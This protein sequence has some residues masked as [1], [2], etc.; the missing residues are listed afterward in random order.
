MAELAAIGLASNLLQFVDIGIKLFSRARES[1]N[2]ASG[3][4]EADEALLADTERL[5]QLVVTIR[6]TSS[7]YSAAENKIQELAQEFDGTATKLVKELEGFRVVVER[8]EQRD[9]FRRRYHGFGK[10]LRSAMKEGRSKK[11]LEKLVGDLEKQ[12]GLIQVYMCAS[13]VEKQ[14]EVLATVENLRRQNDWLEAKTTEKLEYITGDV[15]RVVEMMKIG[16]IDNLATQFDAFGTSVLAFRNETSRVNKQQRI[17]ESLQF[18]KIRMRQEAIKENYGA[19]FRWI[20][21][22][23][24]TSFSRWLTSEN[25]IFWIRGKAGCGKS[26]LMKFLVSEPTMRS[27]LEVWGGQNKLIVASHYFWNVGNSMQKS[28]QGLLQTLLHEVLKELPDVIEEVCSS[29]WAASQH[30]RVA[31]WDEDELMAALKALAK[32]SPKLSVRFCFFID[33]LDEYTAGEDRYYGLCEDLIETLIEL[34]LVPEIKICASSRPWSSFVE[35]FGAGEWQ[36]KMEDLTKDDINKIAVG[37]LNKSKHYE[38]LAREDSRCAQ[39]PGIIANRAQGVILWVRLVVESLKRGLAK[40]DTYEELQARLDELPDDLEKYFQHMLETIEPLYW[41]STTRVFKIMVDSGQTLPLLAFEFLDRE[42]RDAD[43]SLALDSKPFSADGQDLEYTYS[44]LTTRLNERAKDLLETTPCKDG[45]NFLRYQFGFLHRTVR[46]WFREN[47]PLDKEIAK[48]KTKEFSPLLS[49]CRIMLALSKTIPYPDDVPDSNQV[50]AYSDSLMYYAC[51]L[52]ETYEMSGAEGDGVG[53]QSNEANLHASFDLL[54]ELDRSNESRLNY[55]G[56]HWTNFKNPPKGNFKERNRKTFLAAA[57]Q[58]RLSLY[59]EHKITEDPSL[60]LAKEGRPLLDYALRPTMVTPLRLP[61]QEG[62]VSATVEFLLRHGAKPNQRLHMYEGKTPWELFLAVCHV[63]GIRGDRAGI[64][65]VD[66]A[67]A[68][69][70][71]I[72][73]GADIKVVMKRSNGRLVDVLGIGEGLGLTPHYLRQIRDVIQKKMVEPTL[74]D[75]LWSF[76]WGSRKQVGP[77]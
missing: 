59:V 3:Y 44:R 49:L 74:I 70:S 23:A 57:I 54:D 15:D 35:S 38:R 40:A 11:I 28:R 20:F 16:Q 4:A 39:I 27:Q 75:I 29:R 2:S 65:A 26:T 14:K 13:S 56:A 58:W 52:E 10:A 66:A 53:H 67:Q 34:A 33:G 5:K 41:E 51:K 63:H 46:D 36:L 77:E 64:N 55:R 43:Y 62:P 69:L 22:P 47:K 68:I 37:G 19:T 30:G 72:S 31:P 73:H 71:M 76:I 17:L 32:A 42:M 21:D 60:V 6:A 48:R 12:Q 61:G 25:G 8:D 9:S 7:D 18:D 50:F 45:A 24:N 1:Y